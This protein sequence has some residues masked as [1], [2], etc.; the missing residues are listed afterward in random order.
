MKFLDDDYQYIFYS[1][2]EH[3]DSEKDWLESLS[4][5]IYEAYN[6]FTSDKDYK[7]DY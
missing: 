1:I 4:P 6:E 5:E 2:E 7:E 3:Y